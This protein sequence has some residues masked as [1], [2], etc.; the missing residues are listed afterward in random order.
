MVYCRKKTRRCFMK[1]RRLFLAAAALSV[2]LV[3]G[4]QSRGEEEKPIEAMYIEKGDDF[5]IFVDTSTDVLFDA[6]IPEGTE[7]LTTGDLVKIYGDGIMLESYPGQYP[8]VTRI[9][10]TKQGTEEDAEK[11][12]S[13]VDEVYQE[14]DPSEPPYLNLEYRTKEAVVSAVADRGGYTWSYT[15]E[16]GEDQEVAVDAAFVLEWDTLN[17]IRLNEKTDVLL[18]FSREAK[19]VSVIR[20]E[21]SLKKQSTEETEENDEPEGELIKVSEE[22]D[23]NGKK[24]FIL[25]DLLDKG[26]YLVKAEFDQG[27]VEYGFEVKKSAK[28]S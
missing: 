24:Q 19:D 20:Y 12:E 28:S 15:D 21:P 17:D 1:K 16:N 5:Q 25:K 6:Y 4:C 10:V 9:V 26:I 13:L 11:Y 7:E 22:E 2:F 23:E 27:T 3:G 14:P 8:G 18:Y